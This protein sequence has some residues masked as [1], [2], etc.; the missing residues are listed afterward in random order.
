M[1]WKFSDNHGKN[2]C[3]LFHILAFNDQCSHHIETSQ[4]ICWRSFRSP[5]CQIISC[6]TIQRKAYVALFRGFFYSKLSKVVCI[7]N[8]INIRYFSWFAKISPPLKYLS[9]NWVAKNNPREI[10]QYNLFTEINTGEKLSS[11][12]YDTVNPCFDQNFDPC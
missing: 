9:S 3:R 11:G 5:K 2:I 12:W 1:K 8:M 4:L 6:K 10:F 7:V